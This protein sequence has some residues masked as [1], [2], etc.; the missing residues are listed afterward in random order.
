[1]EN[2]AGCLG[3]FPQLVHPCGVTERG[4][5]FDPSLRGRRNACN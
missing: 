2:L 4:S 3:R 5:E 1:M